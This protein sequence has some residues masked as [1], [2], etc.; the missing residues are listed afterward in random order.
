MNCNTCNEHYRGEDAGTVDGVCADCAPFGDDTPAAALGL[1]ERAVHAEI[2]AT[3]TEECTWDEGPCVKAAEAFAVY[4]AD[5]SVAEASESGTLWGL[6]HS[7]CAKP[8]RAVEVLHINESM[9][10]LLRLIGEH[11]CEAAV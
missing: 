1:L 11:E 8:D 10:K 7:P 3:T 5:W 4:L 6:F 2:C 9:P